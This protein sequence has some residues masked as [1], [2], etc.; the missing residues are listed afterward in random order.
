[1]KHSQYDISLLGKKQLTDQTVQLSFAFEI[2]NDQTERVNFDYT[3]GQFIQLLF[4]HEEK[5]IKRSYSIANSPDDF[6]K[7]GVLEITISYVDGGI[8]S[9][10]FSEAHPG[11]NMKLAGPFGILT[12]PEAPKGQLVLV[13]T[14]TGIAPY[15]AMLPELEKLATDGTAITVIMGARH[16]QDVIYS[17]DFSRVETINYRQCLSRE[18]APVERQNEYAGYV[19]QQFRLLNLNPELDLVYLCGNPHMIDDAVAELK[20]TGF[21]VRQIKREKYVFSGH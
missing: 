5:L 18:T 12:A 2:S 20:E 14:G 3:A 9:T 11:L 7:R 6:K 15:R 1:M 10:F 21:S 8:A 4:Q 17:E 13:G 19:Q 16:R